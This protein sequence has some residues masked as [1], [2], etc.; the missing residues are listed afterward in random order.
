MATT[1]LFTAQ[2]LLDM[3]EDAPYELVDGELREVSPASGGP[4]IIAGIVYGYV[5]S[6]V[7][8]HDL[9]FVTV[10]DGGYYLSRHPDTVVAPDVAFI[11]H[12]RVPPDYAFDEYFPVP[13]DLAV[14]VISPSNRPGDVA[15]KIA[16]YLSAGTR[17]VWEVRP[18]ARSVLVHRA[19]R[20]PIELREGDV[21][22]GEDVLLGFRL[23]VASI[24]RPLP[25]RDAG[26]A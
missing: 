7:D 25:R 26:R 20:P 1:K 10:A 16:R 5:F 9:G 11:R 24:F 8:G 23:P 6:F 22:D 17:L 4:S 14:E 19:G 21:L 12:D 13:P 3:G 18:P 15:D 2:D